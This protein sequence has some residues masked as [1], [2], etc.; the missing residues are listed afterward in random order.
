MRILQI[1]LLIT[2]LFGC[3]FEKPVDKSQEN[4]GSV[5]PFDLKDV[6]L[7]DSPFKDAM[8]LD[9]EWLLYLNPDRLLYRCRKSAGLAPK[10]SSYAG[11]EVRFSGH[12]IGHYLSACAMM[13]ASTG[14]KDIKDRVDYIIDELETCQKARGNGYV[15][16]VRYGGRIFDEIKEG[17]IRLEYNGF[18][19]NDSWVPWYNMHKIFA[20][21]IDAYKFADSQKAYEILIKLADWVDFIVTEL[22][23]EQLQEMLQSE[24]GGI[25]ESLAT[26]YSL[27]GEK[28]YLV[29]SKRFTHNEITDPLEIK[30][31]KLDS[32]HANS[33]IPKIIGA[34]KQYEVGGDSVF[35]EISDFFWKTLIEHHSYV[36]GGNAESEYLGPPDHLHD[37]ITDFTNENCG[38]YNMLKLTAGLFCLNPSV[39]KADYYERALYNQI[40]AS[41]NPLTGMVTYFAGADAGSARKYCSPDESFWCCTGTGFEN[42]AKYGEAIYY[43]DNENGLYV[44]LFIP[45]VLN[46]K[47]QGVRLTQETKYP[48]SDQTVMTLNMEHPKEI[49]LKLRYPLWAKKGVVLKINGKPWEVSSEPGSYIDV[50]RKWSDGDV[51]TYQIPMSLLS[52]PILGDSSKK[53]Y[54]YGP[55]VL[56]ADLGHGIYNKPFPVVIKEGM[57]DMQHIKK[58]DP[59]LLT[60]SMEAY[61]EVVKLVPYVSTGE[62]S[63]VTYFSHFTPSAWEKEKERIPANRFELKQILSRSTDLVNIGKEN[64]ETVHKLTEQNSVSGIHNGQTFREAENGWFSY[65]MKVSNQEGMGLFVTVLGE[66]GESQNLDVYIDD[67]FLVNIDVNNWGKGPVTKYYNMHLDYTIEKDE[68]KV[69]FKSKEKQSTGLVFECRMVEQKK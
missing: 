68:V 3:S 55:V 41:Q 10:D 5:F 11:W 18:K 32:K 31:D 44:N 24:H 9:T 60:F 43:H 39:E 4:R 27:T 59:E 40:L 26:V 16:G 52:E 36:I 53:A 23:D 61:P 13:Y 6:E 64:D 42:H 7:L 15:G 19:L 17:D 49:K 57:N 58:M 14:N 29:L 8:E 47:E 62:K 21:L 63:T 25:N 34:L 51:I 54:L 66:Q 38:T 37:R 67:E 1:T 45:S 69:T 56:V 28:K 50:E 35:F 20:G 12:M 30:M 48:Y 33:Q 22:T 2:L 65:K 46:W